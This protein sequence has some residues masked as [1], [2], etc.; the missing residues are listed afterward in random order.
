MFKKGEPRHINSGRKK[1]SK[2]KK[3]LIKAAELLAERD[4]NPVE[5]ILNIIPGLDPKDQARAWLDLLSYCQAKPTQNDADD[6]DDT[7]NPEEALQN[8]NDE[9]LATIHNLATEKQKRE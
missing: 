1:G 8:Y 2:N 9:T 3:R 5:K 6:S 4:I 7:V